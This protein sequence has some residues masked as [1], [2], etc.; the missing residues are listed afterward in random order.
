MMNVKKKLAASYNIKL[1]ELDVAW[2][3]SINETPQQKRN[4]SNGNYYMTYIVAAN[5]VNFALKELILTKDSEKYVLAEMRACKCLQLADGS[6]S[7]KLQEIYGY[8][9]DG[10]DKFYIQMELFERGTLK[11]VLC[12]KKNY[13]ERQAQ[14]VIQQ[15]TQA[16]QYCKKKKFAHRDVKPQNIQVKEW[17]PN[18]VQVKL[19]N[20][21]FS[22]STDEQFRTDLGSPCYQAPETFLSQDD[23][24]RLEKKA[25]KKKQPKKDKIIS[26]FTNSFLKFSSRKKTPNPPTEDTESLADSVA[27]E[28]GEELVYDFK[29]DVYSLGVLAYYLLSG[30][31]YPYDYSN[32][33]RSQILKRAQKEESRG[34][35]R[36]NRAAEEDGETG[37][38]GRDSELDW[39]TYEAANDEYWTQRSSK[40]VD[41]IS[42][43]I[44]ILPQMRPDY[45]FLLKEQEWTKEKGTVESSTKL[46]ISY[47]PSLRRPSE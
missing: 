37:G 16:L 47:V 4:M 21:N 6:S 41:F 46:M 11:E 8:F 1:D 5:G 26:K 39:K 2:K 43:T 10:T 23:R 42:E 31:R 12:A 14:L 15:V 32:K 3:T 35:K 45:D 17:E 36:D 33:G 27:E 40:A 22:K 29:C 19:S 34:T 44:A 18:D 30:G 20:F 28:E 13:S 9:C 24:D 7:D 38:A 25:G